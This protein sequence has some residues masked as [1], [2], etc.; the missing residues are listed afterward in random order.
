MELSIHWWSQARPHDE[1]IGIQQ[2]WRVS[3][4]KV[5]VHTD[6]T[7]P[8]TRRWLQKGRFLPTPQLL[9]MTCLVLL[10]K[11][12][13]PQLGDPRP[14]RWTTC[15]FQPRKALSRWAVLPIPK[16]VWLPFIWKAKRKRRKWYRWAAL[17][18]DWS[19]RSY[20]CIK[21]PFL[22]YVKPQHDESVWLCR[23]IDIAN[24]WHQHHPYQPNNAIHQ[25]KQK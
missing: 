5:T 18:S 25:R 24:H 22:D 12:V 14:R 9:M 20:C 13:I 3:A 2:K 8:N 1:A 21:M 15:V 19:P 10:P 17:S 4:R 6:R 11:P 7:G 23:R 16:D